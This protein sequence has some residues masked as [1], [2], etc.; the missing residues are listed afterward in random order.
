[1]TASRASSETRRS[2]VEADG[3]PRCGER[4]RG[5]GDGRHVRLPGRRA[6]WERASRATPAGGAGASARHRSPRARE[7]PFDAPDRASV[8]TCGTSEPANDPARAPSLQWAAYRSTPAGPAA[9]APRGRA[10]GERERLAPAAGRQYAAGRAAAPRTAPVAST[11]SRAA[12]AGARLR[13]STRRRRRARRE[14]GASGTRRCRAR[15]SSDRRDARRRRRVAPAA[16]VRAARA[17]AAAA[18]LYR[19]HVERRER[20]SDAVLRLVVVQASP[21]RRPASRRRAS[22]L[23]PGTILGITGDAD[24]EAAPSSDV[25]SRALDARGKR[26]PSIA[27]VAASATSDAVQLAPTRRSD[28]HGRRRRAER[29]LAVDDGGAASP[30]RPRVARPRVEKRRRANGD[31]PGSLPSAALA[32]GAWPDGGSRRCAAASSARRVGEL[33]REAPPTPARL[34]PA[35]KPQGRARS[36]RFRSGRLRRA[37]APRPGATDAE[38]RR[39][40]AARL[41]GLRPAR[42]RVLAPPSAPCS[43]R[44]LAAAP[45][46]RREERRQ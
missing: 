15:R 18:R 26:P 11:S 22:E 21:R 23:E 16:P 13:P 1:M 28:Q 4:A 20:A 42:G 14:R 17:F 6:R 25:R 33:A 37:L 12:R 7:R 34:V 19:C 29:D 9:V 45:A 3:P 32:A 8:P 36:S 38:A 41:A 2:L 44:I 5:A 40:V 31:A 10:L 30:A 46:R 24:R 43:R 35:G 27:T 39:E